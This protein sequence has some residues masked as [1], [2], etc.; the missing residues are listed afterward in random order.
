MYACLF[1]TKRFQFC[2]D[3]IY[4]PIIVFGAGDP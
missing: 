1:L 3:G 2:R 4:V